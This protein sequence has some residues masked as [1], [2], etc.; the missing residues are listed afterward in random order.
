MQ[1]VEDGEFFK[2]GTRVEVTSSIIGFQNSWYKAT[3]IC[4]PESNNISNNKSKKS[5][6]DCIWVEYDTVFDEFDPLKKF[7]EFT[8]TLL[9]RPLPP[10]HT[11]CTHFEKYDNVDAY[12]K[13]GWFGG[14]V[15]DVMNDGLEYLVAFLH[16]Y[17][18]FVFQKE[19]IRD[20]FEWGGGT[21]TKCYSSER[22]SVA[23]CTPNVGETVAASVLESTP[24]VVSPPELAPSPSKKLKQTTSGDAEGRPSSDQS[25]AVQSKDAPQKFLQPCPLTSRKGDIHCSGKRKAING[26]NYSSFLTPN[27]EGFKKN[28]DSH[29]KSHAKGNRATEVVDLTN[30]P[31]KVIVEQATNIGETAVAS[32]LE[33]TPAVI[34]PA[35]QIIKKLKQTTSGDAERR[36]SSDPKIVLQS[37]DVPQN[38]LQPCPMT[39]SN[40]DT[41]N[42]KTKASDCQNYSSFPIP[43]NEPSPPV[44]SRDQE[45]EGILATPP[46]YS[47]GGTSTA[48]AVDK[49]AVLEK[50]KGASD[51]TKLPYA[52][53]CE[54]ASLFSRVSIKKP[55]PGVPTV[56]TVPGKWV[57]LFSRM[58]I[59][60]PISKAPVA[61]SVSSAQKEGIKKN[62]DSHSRSLAK[63]NPVTE[64]DDVIS[65]PEKVIYEQ[66]DC[67]S[68]SPVSCS[69][70]AS[71]ECPKACPITSCSSLTSENS[72][73]WPF[74]KKSGMW[75]VIES[76]EVFKKV[77]Q[78]P[79]F[80]PL[81]E[82]KEKLREILAINMMM[83]YSYEVERI[84]AGSPDDRTSI[85]DT[86][87]SLKAL[88]SHG[89][90]TNPLQV[91]LNKL[92]VKMAEEEE[93]KGNLEEVESGIRKCQDEKT[94]LERKVTDLDG[95]IKSLAKQIKLLQKQSRAE[96]S[97]KDWKDLQLAN[98]EA[99]RDIMTRKLHDFQEK[100]QTLAYHLQL[101]PKMWIITGDA[102][103]FKVGEKVEVTSNVTGFTNSRPLPPDLS[104]CSNFKKYDNVEAY[105]KEGWISGVILDVMNNGLKYLVAFL[106]PYEEF[107]F[108]KEKLRVH[109]QWLGG[110]IWTRGYPSDMMS[111]AFCTPNIVETVADSVLESTPVVISPA[112]LAPSPGKE[113][114]QTT[115][116]DAEGRPSS[117]RRNAVQ[118]KDAPQKFIQT[119]PLTSSKGDTQCS[120]KRKAIDDSHSRSPGK[121]NRVTEVV[122]VI[123]EPEKVVVEQVI[124]PPEQTPS[125]LKKLKQS[126]SGHAERRPSSDRKN[127]VQSKDAPQNFLQPCPLSSSKCDT[128]YARKRKTSDGQTYSS[129]SIPNNEP[130]KKND[131]S[132]SSSLAKRNQVTKVVDA[133]NEPEKVIYEQGDCGSKARVS[134]SEPALT[135]SPK[136]SPITSCFSLRSDNSQSWPFTKK[137]GMWKVIESM[138]V[139]KKVPQMPHFSP[140]TRYEEKSR[141]ILAI[142]MMMKYSYEIE[143]ISAGS[144]DDLSSIQGTL[145]SLKVLEWHGFNTNPLQVHL[146]KLL[147]KMEEEEELKRNLEEV[148]S[149]IR[150][151]QDEKTEIE[152]KVTD[153]DGQI[154]SL[155][156]QIKLLQK[157][158]RAE[159]SM[160]DVKDLQ[161][162][163]LETQRDIMTMKLHVF[164]LARK[165]PFEW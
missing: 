6:N 12:Y 41:H 91:H 11:K 127:A 34:S 27:T 49:A 24:A 44:S 39:S 10:N 7:Q 117:D 38:F 3:I 140:L 132:D 37:K 95:Q 149:G 133:I 18:E 90:N 35:E 21:W 45:L 20:H 93:L 108:D 30:E 40:G 145:K 159:K 75:K 97:V 130:I 15:V 138:E 109:M 120:G 89:F 72:Q 29:S 114:K 83:K 28:G 16:P 55:L 63:G 105:Y 67:R 102:I 68:K 106:H 78:M 134:C 59:K 156:E 94:E 118:S 161:L 155:A 76:M 47:A 2:V 54:K 126:T 62:D 65:E 143:M 148:E 146:N 58:R 70:P 141:E 147:V 74:T 79:H 164:Q 82:L 60:K 101:L 128:L 151:C 77:P 121:G 113:L 158:S 71:T 92:L 9:I 50:A 14:V 152:R 23:F 61:T 131:D 111:I 157:Q 154:K 103:F 136:A 13:E 5:K 163:N 139:F 25:D 56:P 124:S 48:A 52:E 135:E 81:N 115:S 104:R 33:S 51:P 53:M 19:K 46:Q 150:K 129:L 162:A 8:D 17:E 99:Q 31:E 84:S 86:L 64:V 69:E 137:S 165:L 144:P 116:G 125:P 43:N 119:C 32:L 100:T 85:Q 1:K 88:E 96:K 42:G 66:G 112:E 36:P 4:P 26:Q 153:L 160:K 107:A 110:R 123:N 87:K 142:N 122:D 98:L 73:S 22:V 57:P 80:S